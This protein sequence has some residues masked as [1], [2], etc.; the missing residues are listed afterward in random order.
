[1]KTNLCMILAAGLALGACGNDYEPANTEVTAVF[2][3]NLD[4]RVQTR[5][6]DEQWT[7]EDAIGIFS[8]NDEMESVTID[9]VAV[10]SNNAVNLK[11]TRTAAG[12]WNGGAT[13][14]RFKN[15]AAAPVSFKAYYPYT[16]DESITGGS[17]GSIDG[18]IAFNAIDQSAA[19][20]VKFDFL[21]AD[22]D[23]NGTTPTGNKKT[24]DVNFQFT[25]SMAKIV[26]VLQPDGSS[27]TDLG[28]MVPTL[29]GLKTKGTFSL[30]GGMVTL[31]GDATA[32]N[33]VLTNQT[34]TTGTSTK[35]SF[36]AIVPPQAAPSDAFLTIASGSDSYRSA[37][38]LGGQVLVVG[39]CYTVTITVKKMELVVT[40][41]DIT[42]WTAQDGG[43]ADAVLQ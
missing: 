39:N 18:A 12:G 13:A 17:T 3:T 20:Q 33:L 25:H 31:D 30:D 7:T 32:T 16:A 22:K 38:I 2:T 29:K 42:K 8:L 9:G 26:V 28:T 19:G 5:M 37:K 43:S 40:G 15:P 1:M 35:Q 4:R 10:P 24:P 27:V 36:V 6:A 23:K 34:E 14:F 11:Y 21:Y 41:S